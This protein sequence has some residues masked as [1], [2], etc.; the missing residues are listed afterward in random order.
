MIRAFLRRGCQ[1][2][3]FLLVFTVARPCGPF[4]PT[5]NLVV[6][7]IPDGTREDWLA[8]R[9]G[10]I[11]PGLHTLDLVVAWRWLSGVGFNGAEQQAVATGPRDERSGAEEWKKARAQAGAGAVE[12]K[13][14]TPNSDYTSN[15][16]IGNHALL[17]AADTLR[18]R[19]AQFGKQSAAVKSWLA[20]QD[21]VFA[22]DKPELPETAAA[23]L[24]LLI[25]QDRAYQK[26]AALHYRQRMLEAT[27]AFG[28]VADDAANP[29]SGWA[30]YALY[31]SPL[32]DDSLMDGPKAD[33]ITELKPLLEMQK[34]SASPELCKAAAALE[35]RKR[36]LADPV[37]FY[38]WLLAN[39]ARKD[40]GVA[41]AQDIEDLRWLR[42][43]EP[44]TLK[45][46]DTQ[47]A[48]VHAWINLMQKGTLD[49]A[50]AAYDARPGLPNLIV[51]M[52][53]LKPEHSRAEAFLKLAQAASKG[54]AYATLV[55]HRLRILVSQ[56]RMKAAEALVDEALAYP[57]AS[58]WPSSLNLWSS[59]KVACAKDMDGIAAHLGRRLASINEGY[60]L[61][62]N[63]EHSDDDKEDPRLLKGLDPA[64]VAW[65]NQ[66][67]PI[68]QWE[69]LLAAPHF[70]V[71]L[72]PELLEALWTRA[73]ILGREDVMLRHQP[74]LAKARPK[75]A[76][77]LGEWAAE[78]D[79]VRRKAQA[80][81]VIWDQRFWPQLLTFRQEAFQYD[82]LY[83]RWSAP[84]DLTTPTP[85]P[86]PGE[87]APD[88]DGPIPG[89]ISYGPRLAPAFLDANAR[90]E[91]ALEA[92]RISA[93]LTWFCEQ[94][95]AFAE[96]RPDDPMASDALSW[97]V[98]SSRKSNRDAK[99]ADLVL[100][101]FRLLHKRYPNSAGAKAAK[102][103]H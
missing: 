50:L 79:P 30:N 56:N 26:A 82:T 89:L 53:K 36:Y 87:S 96:A 102:V 62:G 71:E 64:V 14:S 60:G 70:P 7:T 101:A 74:A 100:K 47:P 37:A 83:N 3:G 57:D 46:K 13:E 78:K 59:I 69:A 8:G 80:F 4:T 72:K 48:G 93:P 95:L 11:Q 73:A 25:R 63:D 20:A 103:Y 42:V 52:Q 58:H 22:W 39:L 17:M 84:L 43:L 38:P 27:R 10:L 51:V 12:V 61:F 76:K 40:R 5:F 92:A 18:K 66:Q 28:E 16:R 68:A 94:A 1:A 2:L 67:M 90:K 33:L 41:L 32:A 97:A 34:P 77:G 45:L 23:D 19:V 31:G 75:A 85:K 29:W 91:G 24:P 99:S 15:T 44:W 21:R 35:N 9:V 54:P 65:L 98:L 55:H 49:E 88:P 6:Q 86:G 81:F